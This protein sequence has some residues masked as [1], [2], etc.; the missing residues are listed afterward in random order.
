MVVLADEIL[1]SFFETDFNSTFRLE[2]V[3]LEVPTSNPT[4]LGS[5]WSNIA[6]DD[7]RKLLNIVTDQIGRTI[8]KHQVC[9]LHACIDKADAGNDTGVPPTSH[10]E[11][12]VAGGAE[13]P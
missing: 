5:L 3:P 12:H 2:P 6:S 8:G 10:W 4:V 9:Y 1:E 13:G 11:D 7:N